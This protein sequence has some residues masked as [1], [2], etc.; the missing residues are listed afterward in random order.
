MMK[1]ILFM[2]LLYC[3]AVAVQAEDIQVKQGDL[4]Y[5]I[6][7]ERTEATVIQSQDEKVYEGNITIPSSIDN[8]PVTTIGDFA[9]KDCI[10]LTDIEI[11]NSV[12]TIKRD[13]FKDCKN[14]ETVRYASMSQLLSMTYDNENATPLQH[15][16]SLYINGQEITSLTID[17]DVKDYAFY[18]AKWLKE[19]QLG[20]HV[21]SLGIGAF[22]GCKGLTSI[23]LPSSINTIKN[24]A[25]KS[26]NFTSVELPSTCTLGYEIFNDCKK[27]ET[28]KLPDNI[29]EIPTGMFNNCNKLKNLTLPSG[30]NTIGYRAFKYCN[31]LTRIPTSNSLTRIGSEAFCGCQGLTTVTIPSTIETIESKAFYKCSN[32]TAIFCQAQ[33]VTT[34]IADAFDELM[35]GKTSLVVAHRLSTIR[36]AD[37]I[38][39][40]DKGKIIEEGSFQQ[41][42]KLGGF[43]AELYN[44][45]L[46]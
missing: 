5:K 30:V 15:T 18:N 13:A 41:L 39:V 12:T 11:P 8:I 31:A 3:M 43:F 33:N 42:M 22:Y 27:L 20:N 35:R 45:Q 46:A 28:V 16:K 24:M 23:S 19:V 25:F 26:C 4:W 38:I 21:T 6:N 37:H 44:A 32:I 1:K 17:T 9:F 14:L 10:L 29:T 36:N 34:T 7:E 40:M 2:L